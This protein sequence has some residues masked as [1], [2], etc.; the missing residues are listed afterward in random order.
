MIDD[1]KVSME[2]LNTNQF[3]VSL[4]YT[5]FNNITEHCSQTGTFQHNFF[6]KLC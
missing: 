5:M 1:I 4:M 2:E 3:D 6:D